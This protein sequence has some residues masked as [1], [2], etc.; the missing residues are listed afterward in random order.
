M[1][2][3]AAPLP[4][5]RACE[6]QSMASRGASAARAGVAA[7]SVAESA[8]WLALG[9]VLW[10]PARAAAC[11]TP[12]AGGTW[13]AV[14]AGLLLSSATMRAGMAAGQEAASVC[15]VIGRTCAAEAAAESAP[16]QKGAVGSGACIM[17]VDGRVSSAAACSM[18][19]GDPRLGS[20]VDSNADAPCTAPHACPAKLAWPF[21]WA[22]HARGGDIGR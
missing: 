19:A 2:R 8:T 5:R 20:S 6:W 10:L 7:V 17:G 13:P 22:A 14:A 4:A 15:S 11:I 16:P 9:L 3:G 1:Q 12:A 18:W 21:R